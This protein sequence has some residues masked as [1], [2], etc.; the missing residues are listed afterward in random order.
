MAL[1]TA[2]SGNGQC[3]EL[4]REVADLGNQETLKTSENLAGVSA[5]I[6]EIKSEESFV[7]THGQLSVR[8]TK[9]VDARG[10][11][12]VLR[13]VSYGWHNWW[14]QYY[15]AGTVDWL[16][17]D[18]KC[19]VVRAAMG[20]GPRGSYL[21]KPEWSQQLVKTVV[22]AAI[23]ND[24]Y[25]II[26][27]HDHNAHR[28]TD[29][30]VEFFTSM[31]TLFGNHPHVIYEIYNEPV[32]A[33]WPEVKRYSKKVI[34][35]IRAVDPDNIILVGSPHWDQDVHLAA[36]DPIV[37][38]KNIMY[39]LHFYAD[40]HKQELRDRGDYALSKGLPLFVSEYGGCAANGDG[41]LN[42]QEWT[43]WVDWMEKRQI[44]W[45]TW[46]IS[47]KNET[48]SMLP[49][50]ASSTGNWP[51]NTLKPSGVQ[52]RKLLRQLNT[53]RPAPPQDNV[54]GTKG[55]QKRQ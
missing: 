26:D 34:D 7:G 55:H 23:A 38:E 5:D 14:H 18:W 27:W 20:V 40:T 16:A 17:A 48:C 37:G 42:M 39:T 10:E 1:A 41:P 51:A 30:A 53:P 35:A 33:P 4:S 13:G 45:V 25:V 54:G 47:S 22:E 19:T 43:A 29:E 44:S 28:H 9:L 24:I 3:Q 31:A 50:E 15:N 21:D 11:P 52:T 46:S 6:D 32:N 12:I 8:G 2:L 36:D 49:A